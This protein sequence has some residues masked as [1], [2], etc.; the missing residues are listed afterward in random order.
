VPCLNR[1]LRRACKQGR[2]PCRTYGIC[3]NSQV[4]NVP[5]PRRPR[6]PTPLLA[7]LWMLA[8]LLFVLS[9]LASVGYFT[10]H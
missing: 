3:F 6:K 7:L 9:L 8:I 2:K 4:V 1:S 5:S 10:P